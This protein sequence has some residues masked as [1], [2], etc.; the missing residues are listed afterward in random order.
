MKR[1]A[2]PRRVG[3]VAWLLGAAVVGGGLVAAFS[4]LSTD[5][6]SRTWPLGIAQEE[7]QAYARLL[8]RRPVDMGATIPDIYRFGASK[9][10]DACLDEQ[11]GAGWRTR[12]F[13]T[14]GY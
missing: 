6:L 1:S 13:E 12:W 4:L 5:R 9:G 8:D 2:K 14:E 7:V 3:V 10:V 11:T